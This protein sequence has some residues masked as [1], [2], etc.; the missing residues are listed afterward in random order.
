M[1][2]W[3]IN[4]DSSRAYQVEVSV[5]ADKYPSF[6]PEHVQRMIDSLQIQD[7]SIGLKQDVEVPSTTPCLDGIGGNSSYLVLGTGQMVCSL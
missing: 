1:E 3:T 7:A 6:P 2:I 4:R 5:G